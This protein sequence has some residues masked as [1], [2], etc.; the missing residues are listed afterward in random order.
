MVSDGGVE[1][2][3]KITRHLS[4]DHCGQV[5]RALYPYSFGLGVHVGELLVGFRPD[6]SPNGSVSVH[7]LAVRSLRAYVIQPSVW[8]AP[9]AS[10]LSP[11]VGGETNLQRVGSL[12]C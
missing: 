5:R 2:S 1:S 9:L 10:P 8:P 12:G 11:D 6:W 3:L 4:V 7:S